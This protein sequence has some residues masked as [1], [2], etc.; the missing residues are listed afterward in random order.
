[1]LISLLCQG[2]SFQTAL[3]LH[4][5][6]LHFIVLNLRCTL[7]SPGEIFKLLTPRLRSSPIKYKTLVDSRLLSSLDGF[8]MQSRLGVQYGRPTSRYCCPLSSQKMAGAG[9]FYLLSGINMLNPYYVHSSCQEQKDENLMAPSP[10]A[11]SL[12]P[13]ALHT[14]GADRQALRCRETPWHQGSD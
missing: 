8:N 11:A 4:F 1:M 13:R 12:R 9:S 6:S 14:C 10:Q 3:P 5:H 7:E 2:S